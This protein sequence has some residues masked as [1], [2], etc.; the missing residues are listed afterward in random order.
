MY[1]FLFVFFAP[2]NLSQFHLHCIKDVSMYSI[3]RRYA[4]LCLL[5]LLSII[6]RPN[7]CCLEV[8]NVQISCSIWLEISHLNSSLFF[9]L[10]SIVSFATRQFPF[11]LCCILIIILLAWAFD[12]MMPNGHWK[13]MQN[14]KWRKRGK[15]ATKCRKLTVAQGKHFRS[16]MPLQFT[17]AMAPQA[18]QI[19]FLFV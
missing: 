7:C 10:I 14:L 3:S 17:I 6:C 5:Q 8:S 16:D 18:F 15:P 11:F 19:P 12:L 1:L 13:Q 4:Q 9:L 2:H